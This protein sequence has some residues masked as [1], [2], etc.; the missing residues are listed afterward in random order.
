LSIEFDRF[1]AYKIVV[2]SRFGQMLDFH[3]AKFG[4]AALEPTSHPN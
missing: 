1:H 3:A 2:A 4:F